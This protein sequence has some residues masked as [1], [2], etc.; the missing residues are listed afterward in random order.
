MDSGRCRA[1]RSERRDRAR[2]GCAGDAGEADGRRRVRPPRWPTKSERDRGRRAGGFE[3]HRRGSYARIRRRPAG[4][5][6]AGRTALEADPSAVVPTGPGPPRLELGR[7]RAALERAGDPGSRARALA[8]AAV[9]EW[10]ARD[11]A[12]RAGRRAGG[13][14]R[15]RMGAAGRRGG[16]ARA[17]R[18][19]SRRGSRRAGSSPLAVFGF[20]AGA[21]GAIPARAEM[22]TPEMLEELRDR[23]LENPSCAAEL[24]VALAPR[25]RGPARPIAAHGRRRGEGGDGRS[26][27]RRRAR[28][29]ELAP[30]IGDRRREP[31][32]GD[33]AGCERR[34][35]AAGAAR[36]A[37]ARARRRDAAGR[38]GPARASPRAAPHAALDAAPRLQ[39]RRHRARRHRGRCAAV[40]AR[41]R[42][43]ADQPPPR[44]RSSPR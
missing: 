35:L 31:R 18:D 42:E 15:A 43:R 29:D 28:R 9:G 12:R 16:G 27:A 20:G 22:P 30:G 41:R 10:T 37:R 36:G 24:R 40:R 3:V 34:R 39:C 17:A 32:R 6:R 33:P 5:A 11:P 38:D 26:A 21:L 14:L 8:R 13:T 7:G 23:L 25:G 19:D 44:R 2:D 4:I 1:R